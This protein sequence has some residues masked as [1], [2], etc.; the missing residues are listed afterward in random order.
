MANLFSDNV[1]KLRASDG[2]NLGNFNVGNAPSGIAF[3]EAV[4]APD[5]TGSHLCA[6]GVTR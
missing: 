3:V 1:T 5:H 4:V 6:K 2:A